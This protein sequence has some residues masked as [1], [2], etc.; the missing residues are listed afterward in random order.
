LISYALWQ[1]RFA[2]D[3]LILG[4]DVL[5]NGRPRTVVGVMPRNFDYPTARTDVWV[6]MPRLRPESLDPGQRSN[7]QLFLVGR[8]R[9]GV[10]VERA[11]SEAV[12]FAR[13]MF[14]D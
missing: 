7:H 14:L 10:T 3:P 6:P 8:L 11:Q 2:G 12:A 1:R 5:L 9:A 13:Q 4:K